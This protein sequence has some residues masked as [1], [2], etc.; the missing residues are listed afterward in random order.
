M[1]RR[2]A[3]LFGERPN[4]GV[5]ANIQALRGVAALMVV[6]QHL[7]DYV[8]A[9]H[10]GYVTTL[11]GSA[12]VDIF[13]VISGFVMMVTAG[14][15][16]LAPGEFLKRRLVR[17]VPLYW[18]FTLLMLLLLIGG[19]KPAGVS[20]WSWSNVAASFLFFPQVRA[21]GWLGPILPV[22]WTLNYEMFFYVVFAAGLAF[23]RGRALLALLAGAFTLLV[24]AGLAARGLGAAPLSYALFVYS[25]PI[26]LEFVAGCAL[27]YAFARRPRAA[28]PGDARR[29]L[30]LGA[31][32]IAA[33]V[34]SFWPG[35]VTEL[36]QG[37]WRALA[38]GLPAFLVVA[39]AVTLERAGARVTSRWV[40]LAGGASYAM[41]LC[42]MFVLQTIEK[43]SVRLAT[44]TPAVI[45]LTALIGVV[46]V[47]LTA[48]FI[49]LWIEAPLVRRLR[50]RPPREF[51]AADGQ[52][53][54]AELTAPK[55]AAS[56]RRGHPLA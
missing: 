1:R 47:T 5:V 37:P 54:P 46:T 32:L 42:H 34:V 19:L 20:A 8:Q 28:S 27:G 4:D 30:W 31:G 39:G 21:D 35:A 49:H 14:H 17:I 55:L 24:V 23:A 15:G 12:G 44:Q 45:A 25:D 43:A 41:Y 38:F 48:V 33:G 52:A 18:L 36:G 29:L 56:G 13:F 51:V 50:R 7:R 6:F 22:G 53:P 10:P 2:I 26:L 3:R 11:I 16:E 9:Q 40:M